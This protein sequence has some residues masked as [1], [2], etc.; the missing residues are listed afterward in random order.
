MNWPTMDFKRIVSLCSEH[1]ENLSWLAGKNV[2][3][4]MYRV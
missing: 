3:R 2:Y 1:I 4:S